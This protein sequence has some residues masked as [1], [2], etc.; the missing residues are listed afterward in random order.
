MCTKGRYISPREKTS[1]HGDTEDR[2]LYVCI[3]AVD[4]QAVDKAILQIHQFIAEHT[5]GW[6]PPSPVRV[7]HPNHPPPAIPII[8]DKVYINLDHAPQS[9]NVLQR[10]LGSAGA[11]VSY[12][13]S[14]TGVS[15]SLRG[16]GHSPDCDEPLHVLIE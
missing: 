8:Q 11:N 15:V 2:P 16:R 13:Q 5:Q 10:A 3:Q 9:F 7:A 14:E 12:I 1:L 4:K 6:S